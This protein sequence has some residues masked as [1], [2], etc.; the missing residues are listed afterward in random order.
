MLFI[1]L[2]LSV[3]LSGC[4]E[5]A[6]VTASGDTLNEGRMEYSSEN[7]LYK[8]S[9]LSVDTVMFTVNGAEVTAQQFFY[10]LA[11]A[12]FKLDSDAQEKGVGFEWDDPY[13]DILSYEQFA[14]SNAIEMCL[15]YAITE[16]W[17]QKYNCGI[18]EE[19]RGHMTAYREALA[20]YYG[21][22]EMLLERIRAL[23]LSDDTYN[24]L[25]ETFYILENLYEQANDES[26]SLYASDEQIAGWAKDTGY[27][28]AFQIFIRT[29][30]YDFNSLD[31]ETLKDKAERA[32]FIAAELNA[33]ND[34]ALKLTRFFQLSD[35]YNEDGS[36]GLYPDGY[37]YMP[38]YFIADFE[39]AAAALEDYEISG[40]VKSDYGYHFIVRMPLFRDD[41]PMEE[42]EYTLGEL[43]VNAQLRLARLNADVRYTSNCDNIDVEHFFNT[44]KDI[45]TDYSNSSEP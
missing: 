3:V 40:P 29:T 18:T 9:G 27:V 12:V 11:E 10:W 8:A 34:P 35:E 6:A 20:Q 39:S 7:I 33:I 25:N 45:W 24:R 26:G 38:G 13:T 15:T 2:F 30:D 1:G 43:Y 42:E 36:A 16:E 23:G 17:A 22:E 41:M 44:L 28:K 21:G 37:L 5:E 4:A 31:A 19:Q 32:K 14:I